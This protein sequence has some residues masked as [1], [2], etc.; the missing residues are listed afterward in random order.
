MLIRIYI[1]P[2]IGTGTMEDPFRS[3]LNDFLDVANNELIAQQIVAILEPYKYNDPI[4]MADDFGQI[5][6]VVNYKYLPLSPEDQAAV[7]AL[8]AQIE[9]FDEIDNPAGRRSLCT[10]HASQATHDKIYNDR[11]ANPGRIVYM[12]PLAVDHAGKKAFLHSKVKDVPASFK[13]VA[14]DEL[15]K[16]MDTTTLTD[17]HTIKDITRLLIHRLFD[18][19]RAAAGEPTEDWTKHPHPIHFAGEDF[20]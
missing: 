5:H 16:H 9:R 1:A 3:I 4:A 12:T 2:Q 20:R 11:K 6:Y 8:Q 18:A 14:K 7:D 15:S 17:E 13:Q 19:Q 10:V